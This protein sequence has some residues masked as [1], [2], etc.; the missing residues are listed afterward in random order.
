VNLI[1][2]NGVP[3][4]CSV[5]VNCRPEAVVF[6]Q[7]TAWIGKYLDAAGDAMIL[8]DPSTDPKL[9]DLSNRGMS[10]SETMSLSTPAAS[11]KCLA[12]VHGAYRC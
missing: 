6:P 8:V 9:D 3:A 11:V 12:R 5:L 10:R 7:E 1:T 2:E 4:D